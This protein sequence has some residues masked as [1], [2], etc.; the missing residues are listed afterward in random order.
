MIRLRAADAGATTATLEP[1]QAC[2]GCGIVLPRSEGPTHAYMNSSPGCW[3]LYGRLSSAPI[4][5]AQGS[6]SRRMAEDAY[7]VQHPGARDRRCVQSVAVHLMGL[8]MLIERQGQ[9]RRLVPVLGRMPARRTLDLHWLEP[10]ARPAR[11]TVHDALQ[12]GSGDGH[13]GAVEAW[14]R[15][16]W[17]SWRPHHATVRG[18]LDVP[19]G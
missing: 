7:A 14:A 15:A 11:L 19:R 18:W 1:T 13:A 5:R 16:V 17:R 8:C 9:Q 3:A 10:P 6:R 2:P 4:A 12:G